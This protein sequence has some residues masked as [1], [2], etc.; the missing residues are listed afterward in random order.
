[1]ASF[2]R[3][4]FIDGVQ[5]GSLLFSS[6][7]PEIAGTQFTGLGRM[8]S[9]FP[10]VFNMGPLDWESKALTTRLLKLQKKLPK[11]LQKNVF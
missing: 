6:K 3:W 11:W 1:M 4:G 2:Y 10:L 9:S 8:K 7:F 5:G